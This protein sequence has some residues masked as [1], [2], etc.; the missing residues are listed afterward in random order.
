ML[1]NFTLAAF[2]A[3]P[4]LVPAPL[5]TPPPA[6]VLCVHTVLVDRARVTTLPPGGDPLYH[7]GFVIR[8][9]AC[10]VK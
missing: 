10:P 4:V 5:H 1:L 7:L 8:E 2:S 3:I 9:G 6:V